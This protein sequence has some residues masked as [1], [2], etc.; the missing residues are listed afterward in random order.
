MYRQNLRKRGRLQKDGKRVD[1]LVMCG[2][3]GSIG[4][5][6]YMGW[7]RKSK[8]GMDMK[9]KE[10]DGPRQRP[11]FYISLAAS[12]RKI[13]SFFTRSYCRKRMPS[14]S[15]DLVRVSSFRGDGIEVR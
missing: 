13:D 2:L 15:P 8:V 1:Q 7:I 11:K 14:S 10:K 3:K 12:G 4:V 9:K 6:H 5:F